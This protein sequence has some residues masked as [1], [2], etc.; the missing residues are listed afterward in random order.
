MELPL[1]LVVK[2]TFVHVH[3]ED[4]NPSAAIQRTQSCPGR[5]VGEVFTLAAST[6]LPKK[7]ATEAMSA[8]DPNSWLDDVNK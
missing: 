5:L 3:D 6:H 7:A 1:D 2:N 4:S 8:S